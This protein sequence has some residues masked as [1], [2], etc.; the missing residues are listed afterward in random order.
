MDTDNTNLSPLAKAQL[1]ME[2]R[3]TADGYKR[4]QKH[5]KQIA[6]NQGD[7]ATTEG[8]KLVSGSIPLVAE[9]I[10]KYIDTASNGG[11]GKT[12]FALSVIREF[13]PEALAYIALN[14]VYMGT[15]RGHSLGH[16]HVNV[17]QAVETEVIAKTIELERSVKVAERI[18]SKLAQQGSLKNKLKAFKKLAKENLDNLEIWKDDVKAKVAEPLIN[19][20]LIALPDIFELHMNQVGTDRDKVIQLTR[21]A[22][23]L[24]S[25]LE[26]ASAWLDPLHRPM[27]VMPRRWEDL[28]TG[29]YYDERAKRTV[30]LVRTFNKDHRRLIRAAIKSGQMQYALDAI[31]AIQETPWAINT[32][33]LEVVKQAYERDIYIPG[34]PKKTSIPVPPK[35]EPEVWDKMGEKEKKGH[36]LHLSGIHEQNRRILSERSV[37]D[38]DLEIA[39]ELALYDRFYLPQNMDFRGRVYPIP[40]FNNQ[41]SD[42]IKGL[43]KFADGLPLGEGGA[44]WLAVHLANCGDFEKVSKKSFDDRIKWVQDNEQDILDVAADP[45]GTILWWGEADS[46]FCFLAACLEYAEWVESGRSENYISYLPVALDGSNSGLQH[47][48]ASMRAEKEAGL[49]SLTPSDKPMDLYQIVAD[50]V[51]D[52]IVADLDNSDEFIRKLAQVALDNGVTR[53]LVKRNV[54]TYAYSSAQFGFRNQ[55]IEDTIRPMDTLVMIGKRTHNPYEIEID[56]K[57]DGGFKVANYLAGKIYRAVTATVSKAQE[58]MDFFKSVAGVLAHEELPLVWTN[59]VGMPIMHKYS[60]WDVK[61]VELFMFDKSVKVVKATSKEGDNTLQRIRTQIRTKP[62]SKIDKHKARSAV[63]PNVIHSMDAAHLLLTVLSAK[64]EGYAHFSLIHDSFGTHAG[65]TERFFQIIREAFVE[66]YEAY[67]PFEEILDAAKEV[68]SDKAIESLPKAP[69]KGSFDLNHILSADYAFA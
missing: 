18:Q 26:D 66:M 14:Y 44:F 32:K 54:M 68:L 35:L 1:D 52:E 36:R 43:F 50:R 48:S 37:M 63:A 27:V 17:G 13:E 42:H 33:V 60:V 16:I 2:S 55:I 65:N 59:P 31:N 15:I 62:S 40:H 30:K 34:L 24:L 3:A 21:D 58:G 29:C 11:R 47:Y 10:Q 28:D 64:D 7:F 61:R 9:E 5:Q 8:K 49:V 25:S 4:F 6:D 51:R 69:E 19:A 23:S 22:V 39:E 12:P 67:D 46:P 45:L 38:R 20:V 56:G 57:K 53:S 41:R